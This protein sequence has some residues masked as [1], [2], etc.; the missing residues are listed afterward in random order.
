MV[1]GPSIVFTR[2]TVVETFIRNLGN[3]CKPMVDTD[4]SQLY[5]YSMCQ[6]IPTGLY[7]QWEFGTESN[8]FKSQQ[9]KSRSS[10]NM[11]MSFFQRQRPDCKIEIFYTTWIQK[12]IDCF[13][14]DGS[15]GH[16]ITVFEAMCCFNHYCQS[17]EARP[18]LIQENGERGNKRG[19]MDRMGKKYIKDN[20]YDVVKM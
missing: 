16:C 17:Q 8:R 6:P 15:C 11:L 13:K 12:K 7:T 18:S 5:T 2:K 4:A 1:G 20:G 9:N 14:V 10:E 3:F 19:I